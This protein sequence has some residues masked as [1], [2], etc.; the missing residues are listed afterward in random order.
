MTC[1]D[2]ADAEADPTRDG[3]TAHCRSCEAR[4]IASIGA[5]VESMQAKSITPHYRAVLEKVFGESWK[6]GH[7][8]VTAWAKKIT[9]AGARQNARKP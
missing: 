9:A 4:A 6:D 1:R 5:H 8:L 2:C 7:A 3:F